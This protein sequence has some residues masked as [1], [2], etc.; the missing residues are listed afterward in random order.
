MR[1]K[2]W[3]WASLVLAISAA[4]G[5]CAGQGAAPPRAPN[6]PLAPVS[7][8]AGQ[9]LRAVATTSIVAD[10]VR[11]VGGEL[12]ELSTLLP[13]GADP[14]AFEPTPRDVATLSSAQVVFANGA[15]LEEFLQRLL[16]NVGD[17]VSV[18]DCSQG[19]TLRTISG[20]EAQ[21]TGGVDPHTWNTAANAIVFVGNIELA[22]SALDPAHAAEYR[23][24]AQS[25]TAQ[26]REL[27]AWIKA[28][29]E[30]IPVAQRRMVTDHESYGYYADRYGLGLVGA[31]IPNVSTVAEPSAQQIAAL[32]DAIHKAGVRAIFVDTT[33]NP[34]LARRVAADTGIQLV[35][36]Y[37]GSLG[38]EG[39]GADTYIG[40][41]RYN[42]SAVVEALR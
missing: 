19:V 42:T 11:S 25:Y 35:R 2:L 8:Q 5:A 34:A 24:S 36:L 31:V 18:V 32:E 26:L 17:K 14:H 37:S 39:S 30:S 6:V 15:G 3:A 33:V 22:L 13:L 10:L 38:S 28:Q 1:G 4:L 7:L 40:Y 20:P 29:I 12:I 21:V 23:A 27:D 41:M 16:R 9:R